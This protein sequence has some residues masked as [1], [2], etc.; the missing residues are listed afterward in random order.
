[1]AKLGPYSYPDIRFGDAVEIAG[2]ILSKFKGTVSVKG[3]AW[4]LGM[5]EGSG[6]LFAK[7]A[8]LRDFGLIEGR[9][10][11]R[12]S[13]LAQRV[14]HPANSDEGHEARAEAF[15]RVELLRQLYTRFEGE[16][17][18]DMSMLV[19]LE[20]ISRA[21]RDEIVRRAPLI[22]KHLTDAIRVLGRPV[23][24]DK[25]PEYSMKNQNISESSLPEATSNP[26]P[27][28]S[29][30]ELQLIAAGRNLSVPLTSEYIEVAITLLQTLKN[31]LSEN[32]ALVTD[33]DESIDPG[34]ETGFFEVSPQSAAQIEMGDTDQLEI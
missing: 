22:Q 5:S 31:E 17:P 30:N 32:E 2:R 25:K 9:G 3:L 13:P 16:V 14:I 18:D 27:I 6:T 24:A 10:E 26:F 19:G 29:S 15:Q 1:M 33:N 4:E 21:P 11:L 23:L 34:S 8:A 12:I 20:E 28:A 7:V